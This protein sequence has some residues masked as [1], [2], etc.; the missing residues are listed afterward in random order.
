[1]E[2]KPHRKRS[3]WAWAWWSA[4][5]A[6]LAWLAARAWFAARFAARAWFAA[7]SQPW[8]GR[9]AQ[10]VLHPRRPYR[11]FFWKAYQNLSDVTHP[12]LSAR[13]RLGPSARASDP[14]RT[15]F[16]PSAQCLAHRSAIH[17]LL[18]NHR[19]TGIFRAFSR[20]GKTLCRPTQAHFVPVASHPET[21]HLTHLF[22]RNS[23]PPSPLQARIKIRDSLINFVTPKPLTNPPRPTLRGRSLTFTQKV[24]LYHLSHASDTPAKRSSPCPGGA[25]ASLTPF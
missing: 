25:A 21:T 8:I 13:R 12:K 10:P 5:F 23:P 7:C 19:F 11:R 16:H 18:A 24:P 9:F 3:V 14:T 17:R 22:S 15:A 4:G 6:A 1:M 20:S 2:P